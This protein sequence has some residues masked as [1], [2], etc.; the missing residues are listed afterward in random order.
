MVI[1]LTGCENKKLKEEKKM[2]YLKFWFS[3]LHTYESFS[4]KNQII[5]S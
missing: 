3:L 2:H 4:A 1:T 5:W